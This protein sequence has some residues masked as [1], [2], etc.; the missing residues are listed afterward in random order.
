MTTRL[1]DAQVEEVRILMVSGFDA[2][3]LASRYG[4][5]AGQVRKIAA[6]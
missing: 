1:S 6:G 3:Y 4:I 2:R 5:T